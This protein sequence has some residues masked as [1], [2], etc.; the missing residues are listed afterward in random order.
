MSRSAPRAADAPPTAPPGGDAPDAGDPLDDIRILLDGLAPSSAPV[1]LAS[2]TIEMAAVSTGGRT[3]H[4]LQPPRRPR[5][6]SWWRPAGCV[7][8]A[9]VLGL[10]VGRATT[11][12]PDERILEYLPVVEHLGVLQEAGSVAF[13]GSVAERGYPPPRRFSFGRSPEE[14][15]ARPD[16][17]QDPSPEG[18]DWLLL[19]ETL[20]ALQ[21]G[22]F[23]PETPAREIDARRERVHELDAESRRRLSDAAK[24]F[25]ELPL[26]RR[27]DLIELARALGEGDPEEELDTLIGAA[28]SWHRWLAWRDPADRHSIVALEAQERLEW[29]DRYARL[30]ARPMFPGPAGRGGP[31]GRGFGGD[32]SG[33]IRGNRDGAA[34]PGGGGPRPPETAGQ[35]E[36]RSVT[37]PPENALEAP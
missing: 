18:D 22:P 8:G 37:A 29:L 33:S 1:S 31:G 16:D 25:Q 13:L 3:A 4:H 10:V 20:E 11:T 19:T 24:T 26:A 36:D 9:L 34:P 14:R 28:R 15:G 2:T 21:E 17:P 7:L 35:A 30:N 27:H 12:D 23:G 6:R 5:S 32:R